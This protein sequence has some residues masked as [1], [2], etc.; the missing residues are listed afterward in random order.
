MRIEVIEVCEAVKTLHAANAQ[1]FTTTQ[2]ID[3]VQTVL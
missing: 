2:L 1:R 3:V